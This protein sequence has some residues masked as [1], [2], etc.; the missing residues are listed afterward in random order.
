MLNEIAYGVPFIGETEKAEW[1]RYAGGDE[2]AYAMKR[3]GEMEDQEIPYLYQQLEDTR[4]QNAPTRAKMPKYVSPKERYVLDD[5]KE[6]EQEYQGYINTPE[7]W[8]GPTGKYLNEPVAMDAFNLADATTA[9]IAADTAARKKATFDKL[10]EMK[11]MADKNWQSQV[12]YAGGG[13]VGIRKPSAIP[14]TGGPQSGGLPSLYN[15]VRK[16]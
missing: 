6:K 13:M 3:M 14:P 16:L 9:K 10:R 12:P 1:M 2:K 5:I 15:N 11:I 7:F 8:E 4:K